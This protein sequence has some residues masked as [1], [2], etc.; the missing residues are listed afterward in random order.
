MP[1]ITQK[2][3]DLFGRT[4]VHV[5]IAPEEIPFVEGLTA[6]QLYATQANLHAVVSFLADSVAQLPLKVYLRKSETERERDRTSSAAKLLYRPNA[7]QTAYEFW[8]A[9]MTELLLMGVATFWIL[10]DAD[11]ESGYQ[12]R[13]IPREWITD[14][15]RKT[16]YAPDTLRIT[17]GTG[18]YLDIPRKEFIQFRMYS[19]G[20]PGSYQSPISAL[21]QTLR[22]QIQ[23]DKFRT[24]LW[25]SSGRFNAYV[26][27]PANVV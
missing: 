17:A 12:L 10:P 25:R 16:N 22:E 24:E 13:V 8:N 21:K 20:N 27:R 4:T 2:L 1:R 11:S 23:A 15:E 7:D 3:R 5:S 18:S 14:T 6:R 9:T 19:P 26:T